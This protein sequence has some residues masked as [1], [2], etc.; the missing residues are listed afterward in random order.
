MPRC[1]GSSEERGVFDEQ[2]SMKGPCFCCLIFTNDHLDDRVIFSEAVA[3][4]SLTSG[5]SE[6]SQTLIVGISSLLVWLIVL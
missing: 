3:N 4:V 5:I 6:L 2:G 1:K